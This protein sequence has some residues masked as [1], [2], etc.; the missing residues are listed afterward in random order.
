MWQCARAV[1]QPCSPPTPPCAAERA[2]SPCSPPRDDWD[3]LHG[4]L[5]EVVLA[6]P[7]ALDPSR[8]D[9]LVIGPGMGLDAPDAAAL[10]TL[11][12][13]YPGAV[14][15][16]ADALTLLARAG[17]V[18]PSPQAGPRVL[19]PHSAEAARLL[20]CSRAEIEADRL[21]A[22]RQLAGLGRRRAQGTAQPHLRP[23]PVR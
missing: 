14:L 10:T 11:W 13:R 6:E 9:A 12:T 4:L 8:H 2:S 5:P 23:R 1:A 20:G 22:S 7:D 19:T 21:G 16:D 17:R 3:R 18:A 15:A